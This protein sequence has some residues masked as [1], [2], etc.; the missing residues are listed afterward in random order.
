[1]WVGDGQRSHARFG[2]GAYAGAGL[3]AVLLVAYRQ[4]RPWAAWWA[5]WTLPV[6]AIANSMVMRAPGG[7]TDSGRWRTPMLQAVGASLARTTR[8]AGVAWFVA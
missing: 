8:V 2:G 3:C 6:F 7:G 1:M 5:M 4:D